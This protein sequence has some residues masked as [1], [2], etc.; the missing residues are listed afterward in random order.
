MAATE[1]WPPPAAGSPSLRTQRRTSKE[2]SDRECCTSVTALSGTVHAPILTAGT[3]TPDGSGRSVGE[4]LY[5]GN[6]A[7]TVSACDDLATGIYGTTGSLVLRSTAGGVNIDTPID[8]TVGNTTIGATFVNVKQKIANLKSGRNLNITA[9]S[10]LNVNAV[11]TGEADSLIAGDTAIPGGSATLVGTD[12][13]VHQNISTFIGP[14]NITATAG[15]LGID[16]GKGVRTGTGA[17]SVTSASN[18][19]K[20]RHQKTSSTA[21]A[22]SLRSTGG[23]ISIDEVLSNINGSFTLDANGAVLINQDLM[24]ISQP[25]SIRAGNG[26]VVM[27]NGTEGGLAECEYDVDLGR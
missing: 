12:I 25:I 16:A 24:T 6:A 18:F 5:A 23:S 26:G 13:L 1:T 20:R 27:A 7:I 8:Q 15:R 19:V 3:V 11:I 4:G 17:I 14:L 21:G 10:S 2:C 22:I 9:G